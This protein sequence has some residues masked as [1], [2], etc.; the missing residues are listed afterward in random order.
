MIILP[1][2]VVFFP[3]LY[4]SCYVI[5][6]KWH[7]PFRTMCDKMPSSPG[8]FTDRVTFC[9][10]LMRLGSSGF[11]NAFGHSLH[12]TM[13]RANIDPQ[14]LGRFALVPFGYLQGL[15]QDLSL[16]LLQGGSDVNGDHFGARFEVSYLVGEV[17]E[18]D[19]VRAVDHEDRFNRIFQLPNIAAPF[20]IHQTIHGAL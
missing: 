17:R 10:I 15:Q 7:I 12:F 14:K 11:G 4:Q 2:S 16:H 3:N 8:Q 20:I 5:R 1:L 19:H 13:D 18:I 6:L 9:P